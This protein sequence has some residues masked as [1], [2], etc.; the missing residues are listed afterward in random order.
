[1]KAKVLVT[2]AAGRTGSDT[3]LELLKHGYP[4]RAF[5]RTVDGRSAALKKAGAEIHVGD[6]NDY[7]DLRSALDGVQRAYHCPPF[8][9]NLLHNTMLF[10]LACEAAKLEVVVLMSQW[11]PQESHPSIISRDHWISN[12]IY[13]WM[14]SVDVIHLNPG[15]FLFTYLLGLPAAVHWGMLMLPFDKAMN[16]PVSHADIARVAAAL[17]RDPKNHIG[18]SYRPTGPKL[19]SPDE[20]ASVLSTVVGRKIRANAASFRLFS[21]AAVAQGFPLHELAHFRHYVDDLV[22]GAYAMGAPT[23]HVLETTGQAAEPLIRSVERYVKHP[24]L[25]HPMLTVGTKLQAVG[26][27]LRMFATPAPDLDGWE[28]RQ[29]Y[30]LLRQ[31]VGSADHPAWVEAAKRQHLYLLDQNREGR[32]KNALAA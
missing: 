22:E 4:V 29:G 15:I 21:K 1:M 6:L 30:P 3:V 8:A 18:R 23:N 28:R 25:I 9:P 10:A 12:Q 19:V 31:P 7:R 14:P 11:Q 26:L 27:L 2:A 32:S 20:V 16:A 5:V 17:L 24:K 13:R